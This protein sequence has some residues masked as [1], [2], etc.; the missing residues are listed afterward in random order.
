[1]KTVTT[2]LMLAITS[3]SPTQIGPHEL[4]IRTC[5]RDLYILEFYL[6]FLFWL[7]PKKT[8]VDPPNDL[9]LFF[10]PLLGV[11]GH[12]VEVTQ[13]GATVYSAEVRDLLAVRVDA[14]A[15]VAPSSS[16]Q[17]LAPS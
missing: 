16:P 4:A 1:M 11:V 9:I 13:L 7:F 10:D 14:E 6:I 17:I 2:A 15:D 3:T 12:V 8:R 5:Y